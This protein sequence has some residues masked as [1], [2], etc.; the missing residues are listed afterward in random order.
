[1]LRTSV[2]ILALAL[3]AGCGGGGSAT[4]PTSTETGELATAVEYVPI[5]IRLCEEASDE[6]LS[7][8]VAAGFVPQ[9]DTDGAV[10]SIGVIV[11]GMVHH[12]SFA[13]VEEAEC[14]VHVERPDQRVIIA[15]EAE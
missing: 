11:S 3:A 12:E 1:M 5:T 2:S 4:E 9:V 8:A 15:P 6:S 7:A 13:A 10:V 14:V